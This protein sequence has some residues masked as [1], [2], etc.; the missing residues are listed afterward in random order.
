MES[1]SSTPPPPLEPRVIECIGSTCCTHPLCEPLK[2]RALCRYWF[3][4]RWQPAAGM[5]PSEVVRLLHER[6][7]GRKFRFCIGLRDTGVYEVLL[8]LDSGDFLGRPE[9]LFR[10]DGQGDISKAWQLPCCWMAHDMDVQVW[11]RCLR[12]TDDRMIFAD[13]PLPHVLFDEARSAAR[14]L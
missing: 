10:L 2:E 13:K 3:F 9:E 11:V 7:A 4:L 6:L 14:L 5:V 12:E 1:P 8:R